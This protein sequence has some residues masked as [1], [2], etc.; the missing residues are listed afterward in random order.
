MGGQ[1]PARSTARQ[2]RSGGHCSRSVATH[3]RDPVSEARG[4]LIGTGA[5]LEVELAHRFTGDRREGAPHPTGAHL[6][7]ER[8][9][10]HLQA[11]AIG[12]LQVALDRIGGAHR[13]ISGEEKLEA[14][15]GLGH[16]KV[17][18]PVRAANR[19]A[20]TDRFG[21]HVGGAIT[22]HRGQTLT[23]LRLHR[24]QRRR[25]GDTREANK[26]GGADG[27]VNKV[28][29]IPLLARERGAGN[30]IVRP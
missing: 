15:V 24:G 28:L 5:D 21:D 1:P 29:K 23:G 12:E 14:A 10:D 4:G 6:G 18:V 30:R 11:G 16:E 26:Q 9:V 7:S 27:H 2:R 13:G 20:R 3:R 8:L 17:C 22:A 25:Q 19:V